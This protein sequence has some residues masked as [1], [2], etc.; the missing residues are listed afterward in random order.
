MIDMVSMRGRQQELSFMP[1]RRRRGGGRKPKRAKAGVPHAKRPKL[2]GRE[3]VHV[4][5][6]TVP[7]VGGLRTKKAYQCVRR[8]L[9]GVATRSQPE[10]R[11]RICHVSIQG[12]HIHAIAEADS[13]AALSRGMQGFQISLAKQLNAASERSGQVFVD[14]YHMRVLRTPREVRSCIAYV[15]NNWRHHG[16]HRDFPERA[17]DPYTTGGHFDGWADPPDI[18]TDERGQLTTGT[19]RT[20]LLRAGWRRHGLIAT[21]EVPG[22]RAR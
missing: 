18:P 22:P 3:P 13:N 9:R 5:L 11:F 16:A 4:T 20:W 6:S 2:S 12:T 10:G 7:E 17:V 1:R 19:P 15:L 21:T 14:R 8:A